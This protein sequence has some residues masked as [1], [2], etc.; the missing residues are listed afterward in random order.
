MS[1]G[2]SFWSPLWE[3][4]G[5]RQ[6]L[7]RSTERAVYQTNQRSGRD[8]RQLHREARRPFRRT[9]VPRSLY[10]GAAV[11]HPAARI[12]AELRG[13][14]ADR[15][16]AQWPVDVREGQVFD[17]PARQQVLPRHAEPMTSTTP[18]LRRPKRPLHSWLP[19]PVPGATN[20]SLRWT[21]ISWTSAR[22]S[23]GQRRDDGG[24]LRFQ[25][26]G[27]GKAIGRPC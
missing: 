8:Q 7:R 5:G 21:R 2:F 1:Q 27:S 19:D 9:L 11:V 20:G 17:P 12:P 13:Q 10:G 3:V 4:L 26:R 22:L 15:L 6:S 23:R 25:N 18:R 14:E 16:G 24:F